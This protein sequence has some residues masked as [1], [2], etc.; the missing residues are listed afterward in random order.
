[1][2]AIA[3]NL[4]LRV[5][6]AVDPITTRLALTQVLLMNPALI[7]PELEQFLVAREAEFNQIPPERVAGLRLIA[8]YIRSCGH[9]HRTAALVFIC[10]HNSRRSHFSQIWAQVAAYR[11]GVTGVETFSGGT[12][13]TAMN[14]RVADSL[15]RS[16]LAVEIPREFAADTNPRY[17]VRF[18]PNSPPLVC[19]S[20]I[21]NEPPNPSTDFC[22]VMTCAHADEAC[23]LVPSCNLRAAIRYDD[24]KVSDNT[25][26]EASTYDERS[27]QICREMLLLMHLA[28][29]SG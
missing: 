14:S 19:F 13:V 7:T 5:L 8:D 27:A 26:A 17:L 1:M 15:R 29:Q 23:P 18:A 11:Y 20:K 9:K 28:R 21:H 16:G 2:V 4:R 6:S 22:A 25:P 24:P 3:S 10:T 12:E